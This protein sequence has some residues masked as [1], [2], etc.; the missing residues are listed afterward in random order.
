MTFLGTTGLR[1]VIDKPVF[2]QVVN[3]IIGDF[4]MLLHFAKPNA[5]RI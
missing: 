1:T 3:S 5:S 2:V 4:I